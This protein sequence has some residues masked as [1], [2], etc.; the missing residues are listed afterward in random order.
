MFSA[1]IALFDG[2][3]FTHEQLRGGI[4]ALLILTPIIHRA[5]NLLGYRLGLK[6]VP[7]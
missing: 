4:V 3:V 1:A 5:C 6:S 2:Q 7:F